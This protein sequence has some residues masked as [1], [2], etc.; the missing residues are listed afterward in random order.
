VISIEGETLTVDYYRLHPNDGSIVGDRAIED[1][2][3]R[4]KKTVTEVVFAK[5][6][7]RRS[8]MSQ[9]V[10]SSPI[11]APALLERRRMRT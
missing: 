9:P 2:V 8:P 6:S 5:G 1:E 7:S 4:L 3:V 11:F 10:P